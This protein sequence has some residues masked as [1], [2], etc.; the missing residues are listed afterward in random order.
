MFDLA[1]WQMIQH[2]LIPWR[3]LRP[4]E[5]VAVTKGQSVAA[6]REAMAAG[7]RVFGE[8]YVQE[9]LAKQRALAGADVEWHFIGRLQSNKTGLIAEHFDWVHGVTNGHQAE[10]LSRARLLLGKGPLQV[11]LQVNLSGETSKSGLAEPQVEPCLRALQGLTGLVVRGLMTL[12][13]PPADEGEGY[14]RQRFRALRQLA[15]SL[16]QRGYKLD[17]LSM[18]MSDDYQIALEEGATWVRVGTLLFGAREKR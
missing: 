16:C 10:R 13:E 3:V 7:V 4:V 5:V 15:E 17:T 18:G 14:T 9:A 11:C 1:H 12:P 2:D 6:L 8:S